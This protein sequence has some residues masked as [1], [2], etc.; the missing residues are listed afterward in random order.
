MGTGIIKKGLS[1]LC[2]AALFLGMAYAALAE[3]LPFEVTIRWV[4]GDPGRMPD[5]LAYEYRLVDSVTGESFPLTLTTDKAGSGDTGPSV[6][7]ATGSVLLPSAHTDGSKAVYLLS[8]A[9]SGYVA[10]DGVGYAVSSSESQNPA[11]GGPYRQRTR[12]LTQQ[13][14]SK[15][16]VSFEGVAAQPLRLTLVMAS[17]AMASGA[18]G[19]KARH[20]AT[21]TLEDADIQDFDLIELFSANPTDAAL[22][23]H[24]TLTELAWDGKGIAGNN[25][26]Q[27]QVQD[28]PG[29]AVTVSGNAAEG[30]K[31]TVKPAP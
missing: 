5:K 28:I 12:I 15:V 27:L 30:F 19:G 29:A 6:L 10:V 24:F 11:D 2:A 4:H 21:V 20:E 25:T 23:R 1:L 18:E 9:G 8:P 31:I 16:A 14:N 13:L 3:S 17:W 7:S 26:Y 22:F